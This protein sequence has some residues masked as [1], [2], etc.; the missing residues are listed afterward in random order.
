MKKVFVIMPFT[1]RN[2]D[3]DRYTDPGHWDE[4]YKGLILPAVEAVK[5]FELDCGRDDHDLAQRLISEDLFRKI[6][7]ADLIIA[8][9]SSYNPNVFIELGWALRADRRFVLIQDDLTGYSFDINQQHSLTYDHRLQP[10]KLKN[11]CEQLSGKIIAT[12]N[13]GSERYSLVNRLSISAAA[14]QASKAGDANAELLLQIKAQL[15]KLQQF[16]PASCPGQ[17]YHYD[18]EPR[19]G[20]RASSGA[21]FRYISHVAG[22]SKAVERFYEALV[23]LVDGFKGSIR[24]K[25]GGRFCFF[26]CCLWRFTHVGTLRKGIS[27]AIRPYHK[28]SRYSSEF[29]TRRSTPI[30]D[31]VGCPLTF[32][33]ENE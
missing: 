11:D 22:H 13:A 31:R 25:D 28:F 30:A 29:L 20:R 10:T 1:V 21:C 32:G 15:D 19:D 27:H 18:R 7:N 14:I 24:E 8:D 3:R 33:I 12:L 23:E 6:E 9:L 16:Q 26:G 17:S 4:V 5:E 2:P